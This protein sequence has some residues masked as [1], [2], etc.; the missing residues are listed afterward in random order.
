MAI[1]RLM[2]A[3]KFASESGLAELKN[4]TCTLFVFVSYHDN[5]QVLNVA[6]GVVVHELA[7]MKLSI[8]LI[9][10]SQADCR[11]GTAEA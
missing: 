10:M 11:T 3:K 2:R 1:N 4:V 9:S 7:S 5:H 6:V 8:Q